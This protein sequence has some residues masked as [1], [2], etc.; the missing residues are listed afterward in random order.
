MVPWSHLRQPFLGWVTTALTTEFTLFNLVIRLRNLQ[1]LAL[2][3]C[4]FFCDVLPFR[5]SFM[6]PVNASL[7][8]EATSNYQKPP[9]FAATFA[10]KVHQVTTYESIRQAHVL[11]VWYSSFWWLSGEVK[12][13]VHLIRWNLKAVYANWGLTRP[14]SRCRE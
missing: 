8:S 2:R 10:A 14:R 4:T 9:F 5:L 7:L 11:Q 3:L 6:N 12:H 1:Q 13:F